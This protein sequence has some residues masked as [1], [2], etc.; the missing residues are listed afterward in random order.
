MCLIEVPILWNVP[1]LIVPVRI[2]PAV[3]TIEPPPILVI[4]PAFIFD[5]VPVFKFP[6]K[7]IVPFQSNLALPIPASS[8]VKGIDSVPFTL[9]VRKD[10]VPS[11]I[12]IGILYLLINSGIVSPTSFLN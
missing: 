10:W 12:P 11:L 6:T 3:T 9:V 8:F 7:G 2:V 1:L 4:V 5:I